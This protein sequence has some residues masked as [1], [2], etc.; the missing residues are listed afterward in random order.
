MPS[1]DM[2]PDF[3]PRQPHRTAGATAV[4]ARPVLV[5]YN[6]WVSSVEVARHGA[7][8]SS[9]ARPCAPWAWPSATGPRCRAT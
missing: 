9:A 2:A 3:G 5:A 1:T 8:R 6:V 4:G 7:P